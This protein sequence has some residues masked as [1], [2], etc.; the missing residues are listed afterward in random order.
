MLQK[1]GGKGIE[2][3]KNLYIIRCIISE[4]AHIV[5]EAEESHSLLPASWRPRQTPG[6]GSSKT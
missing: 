2:N 5:M 3:V 1:Q 4:L 6:G